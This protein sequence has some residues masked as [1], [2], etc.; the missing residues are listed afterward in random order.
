M[1][2]LF[3]YLNLLLFYGNWK[4]SFYYFIVVIFAFIS[5]DVRDARVGESRA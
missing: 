3:I 4:I 5:G 2:S 1:L